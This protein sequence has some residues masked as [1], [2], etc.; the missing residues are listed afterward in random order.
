MLISYL[1]IAFFPFLLVSLSFFVGAEK[2]YCSN[3]P[4]CDIQIAYRPVEV[5]F[6]FLFPL[7]SLSLPWFNVPFF[8]LLFF[9]PCFDF[10]AILPKNLNFC[11]SE[12]MQLATKGSL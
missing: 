7:F 3:C 8:T 12:K 2:Q 6:P 9:H 5:F 1:L 10:R 11:M 4:A